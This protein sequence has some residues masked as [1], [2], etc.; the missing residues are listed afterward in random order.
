MFAVKEFVLKILATPWF[1][2][3][4]LP[5]QQRGVRGILGFCVS[6][7]NIRMKEGEK[8][9]VIQDIQ[10]RKNVGHMLQDSRLIRSR[11]RQWKCVTRW[12]CC[13]CLC[14]SASGTITKPKDISQ[15]AYAEKQETAGWKLGFHSSNGQWKWSNHWEQQCTGR[16]WNMCLT[17][18]YVSLLKMAFW[19][20]LR[21]LSSENYGVKYILLSFSDTRLS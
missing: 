14:A 11:F 19:L 8:S 6:K 3:P 20:D 7:S 12:W 21:R 5:L 17:S 15:N 9:C 13:D 18:I 2:W 4:W 1:Q 16:V 10:E